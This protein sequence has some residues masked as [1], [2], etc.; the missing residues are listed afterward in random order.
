MGYDVGRSGQISLYDG[1]EYNAANCPFESYI[2]QSQA[3]QFYG[4]RDGME[5]WI[6]VASHDNF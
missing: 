4:Q 1:T 2:K 6:L 5:Y 3:Q